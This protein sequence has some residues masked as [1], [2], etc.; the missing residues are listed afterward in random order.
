MA[1]KKGQSGNPNGR[2][3]TGRAFAEA[4]RTL[5][6]EDGNLEAVAREVWRLARAGDLKAIGLIAER[7]DGRPLSYAEAKA[8][9]VDEEWGLMP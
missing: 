3:R 9:R 1:W 7:L 8:E 5:A 4:V 6:E 2:P